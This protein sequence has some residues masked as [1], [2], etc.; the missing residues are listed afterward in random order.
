MSFELWYNLLKSTLLLTVL[1]LLYLRIRRIK[2]EEVGLSYP[3]NSM[4]YALAMLI[5]ALPFMLYGASLPEFKSYYPFW[6]PARENISNLLTLWLA[7]FFWMFNTEFFFRGFLLFSL[8]KKFGRSAILLQAIPYFLVHFGKPSLELP[9]S[10][11][12][13][14]VFGY[15]ALRTRSIFPSFFAHWGGAVIFDLLCL[16]L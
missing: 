1:P 5:L 11:F 8:E 4:R 12:A 9:Y 2:F 13:G 10:F 6:Q 16:K 15:V 7:M 3:K 14:L